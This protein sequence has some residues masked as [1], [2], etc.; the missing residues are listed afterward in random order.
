MR[1]NHLNHT[2]VEHIPDTLKPGILYISMEYATAAHSCCCGC[3]EEIITPF[4]PTDWRMTFDGDSV[5]ISPS[6]GNWTLDCS[7]HYVIKQGRIIEAAPWTDVQVASER[8][9]DEN[10]KAAHY[11]VK[12]AETNSSLAEVANPNIIEKKSAPDISHSL[13]NIIWSKI[14]R[15]W[16]G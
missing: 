6:I 2:F 1:Y 8:E 13:T 4:T 10:A 12:N 5:S 11:A 9:R 14:S 7:S 3:G 15:L 16:R